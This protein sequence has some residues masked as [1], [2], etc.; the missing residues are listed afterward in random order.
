MNANEKKLLAKIDDALR[1]PAIAR[2]IDEIADH[3]EKNFIGSTESLAWETVPLDVY[4]NQLPQGIRS[5]W[6]FLLRQNSNSGAER[7]PNS[8]QRVASWRRKGDLQIW[9]N[10]GWE[11]HILSPDF[12][13][14]V[15]NRWASIS[16]NTWH[17]AVV[18]PGEHWIVVS[19]HTASAEELIEERPDPADAS[20]MRQRVYTKV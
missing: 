10:D 4:E 17:Q 15:E 2:K 6:V 1:N 16:V 5:S 12:G 8:H 9:K 19:F 20:L 7:H 13:E 11:S 18:G 14:S 3:V